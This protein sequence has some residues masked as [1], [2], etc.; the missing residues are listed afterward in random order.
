MQ[1]I[2]DVK[3]YV[4]GLGLK[5]AIKYLLTLLLSKISA[6]SLA[7]LISFDI[8]GLTEAIFTGL[9]W[10]LNFLKIKFPKIFKFL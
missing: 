4:F 5:K 3:T 2:N 10:L 8:P 1:I 9:V 6:S 7:G